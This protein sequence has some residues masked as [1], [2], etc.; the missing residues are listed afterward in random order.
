MTPP[1]RWPDGYVALDRGRVLVHP[2]YLQSFFAK[3]WRT[4][5][6]IMNAE[7]DV[8]RRV[9]ERDNCRI[10]I[11]G[12]VGYLKRHWQSKLSRFLHA[13]GRTEADGVRLC[14]EADVP[15][16][17]VIAAGAERTP[18]LQRSFFVSEDIGGVPAD[19]YWKADSDRRLRER[20]IISTAETARKFHSA[21]LYHRDFYWCHFFVRS[22]AAGTTSH[23]IDLQRVLHRPWLDWRWRVKDLG[24]FWFS[25]PRDVT[26]EDRSEWF[27]VYFDRRRRNATEW[28]AIVRAN[29][30]RL[31]DR[32]A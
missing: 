26:S 18:G 30:Y 13:P 31:K 21:G 29:F 19:D 27:N 8:V 14:D 22:C 9:G 20:V 4:L 10:E 17:K 23:L 5:D 28:A 11:G 32:A 1:I 15:T 2:D 7:V 3:R 12:R 24:Q 25:A 6:A 16:M